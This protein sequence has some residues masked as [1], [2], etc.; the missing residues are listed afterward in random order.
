[1]KIRVEDEARK[2][3]TLR[4]R[5]LTILGPFWGPLETLKAVKNSQKRG[6]K[7]RSKKGS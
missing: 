4:E 6:V 5:F 7:K 3:M 1:M 2:K